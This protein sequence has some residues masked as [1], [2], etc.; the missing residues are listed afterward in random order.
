MYLLRPHNEN[1]KVVSLGYVNDDLF[2]CAFIRKIGCQL[3]AQ[4]AGMR[5]YNAV[6]TGVI[7]GIPMEHMNPNLL[8]SS[9]SG[10]LPNCTF[11]YVKQKLLQAKRSLKMRT[12]G[13]PLDHMPSWISLQDLIRFMAIY[14]STHRVVTVY[15]AI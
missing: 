14:L 11:G 2:V 4:E 7:A 6:F 10:D 13:D 1:W 9:I 3:L 5:S 15:L 8:L 12:R